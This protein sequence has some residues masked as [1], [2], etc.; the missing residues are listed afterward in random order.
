MLRLSS[1]DSGTY[2]TR[3]SH[4]VNPS[5]A[6]IY[7]EN[8]AISECRQWTGN[9]LSA[10]RVGWCG[11]PVTVCGFAARKTARRGETTA[12]HLA[13]T[14]QDQPSRAG[15]GYG[16]SRSRRRRAARWLMGTGSLRVAGARRPIRRYRSGKEASPECT[17]FSPFNGT[18]FAP[19][20][21]YFA[22]IYLR[23]SSAGPFV[24]TSDAA[25]ELS[26]LWKVFYSAQPPCQPL[27]CKNL[28]G[29]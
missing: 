6:R 2:S 12:A 17:R 21:L 8:S 22:A 10:Y 14:C 5:N 29:K 19:A 3:P 26:G 7:R 13:P 18:H 20:S 15:G 25:S 28:Q 16:L 9:A 24:S 11:Q 23:V 4:H 27:K 1:R